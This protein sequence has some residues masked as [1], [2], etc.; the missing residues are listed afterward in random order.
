M[1]RCTPAD[2][3]DALGVSEEIAAAE[4]DDRTPDQK[5]AAEK[6]CDELRLQINQIMRG[7]DEP[8]LRAMVSLFERRVTKR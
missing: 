4:Q 2:I 1:L 5:E 8:K 3:V 7:M 6:A